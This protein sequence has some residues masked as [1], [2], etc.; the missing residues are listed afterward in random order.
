MDSRIQTDCFPGAKITHATHLL[1]HKTPMK[2]KVK[3]VFLSFILND[4]ETSNPKLLRDY[5]GSLFQTAKD[6]F[7]NAVIYIPLINYSNDLPPSVQQNINQINEITKSK[8]AFMPRLNRNG[9]R[10]TTDN[11]HWSMETGKNMLRH[12]LYFLG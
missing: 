7:P 8:N 5:I 10:T 3:K 12:W 1:Q 6:K 4:R 11:I 2:P 9:F